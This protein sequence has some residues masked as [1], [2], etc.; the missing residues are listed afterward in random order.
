M[1]LGSNILRA[2][3]QKK[4]GFGFI[5]TVICKYFLSLFRLQ[6]TEQNSPYY[7]GIAPSCFLRAMSCPKIF[8]SC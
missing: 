6:T 8:S 2:T 7:T 5:Q 3:P 4:G 1:L